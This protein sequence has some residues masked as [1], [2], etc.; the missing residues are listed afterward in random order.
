LLFPTVGDI[1]KSVYSKQW[2]SG[3]YRNVSAFRC[4]SN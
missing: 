3:H 4:T 1:L 2:R